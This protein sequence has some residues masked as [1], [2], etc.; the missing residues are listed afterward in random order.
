MNQQEQPA[1]LIVA[2][3]DMSIA[4]WEATKANMERE[5]Y[6]YAPTMVVFTRPAPV[7]AADAN[8]TTAAEEQAPMPLAKARH[9]AD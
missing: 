6:T 8:T 3:A 9:K 1:A 2:T 7:L 4:A 5:G